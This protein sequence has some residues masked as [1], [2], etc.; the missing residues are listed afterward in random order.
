[1]LC[2]RSILCRSGKERVRGR[3]GDVFREVV[4]N[5]QQPTEDSRSHFKLFLF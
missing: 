3:R 5:E 2:G 1:M 4:G